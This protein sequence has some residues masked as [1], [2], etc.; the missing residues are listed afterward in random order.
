MTGWPQTPGHGEWSLCE[1]E[2]RAHRRPAGRGV[3][4]TARDGVDTVGQ[5]GTLRDGVGRR[6]TE[7]H[8]AGQ[9]G[10]ARDRVAILVRAFHEPS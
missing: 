1:Q 10:T 9:S 2:A 4:G 8:T 3:G 7:S 5:H 6:G